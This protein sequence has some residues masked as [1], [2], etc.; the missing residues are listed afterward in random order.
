MF[1]ISSKLYVLCIYVK[2]LKKLSN[3]CIFI[4]MLLGYLRLKFILLLFLPNLGLTKPK[5][6]KNLS[7]N[8][9]NIFPIDDNIVQTILY[10][11]VVKL[12]SCYSIKF[13]KQVAQIYLWA[14]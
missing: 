11:H 3:N 4:N 8:M 1:Q 6:R 2:G 10:H 5:N 14:L 9:I 13:S 12:K 7:C